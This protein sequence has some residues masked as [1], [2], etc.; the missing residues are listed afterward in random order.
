MSVLIL[1]VEVTTKNK[2]SP[3]TKDNKLCQIGLME[4]SATFNI[5]DIEYSE[6]PYGKYLNEVQDYIQKSHLLVGFNIKFDLHWLRRYGIDFSRSRIWDC[7]IAHFLITNQQTKFPSLDGVCEYYGLGQ[8]VDKIKHY[9]DEGIDTPNISWDELSEYLKQDL[10]L[11]YKVYLKQKEYFDSHPALYR[12][13]F[14][15][16]LDLPILQEMEWNGMRFDKETSLALSESTVEQCNTIR[17]K[18]SWDAPVSFTSGDHISAL[19]YGG[20]IKEKYREK[21]IFQYK[22]GR[23]AEKERWSVKEHTMPQLVKPLPKSEMAKEGFYATDKATLT[24]IARKRISKEIK[25]LI[26]DII[27]YGDLDH[28]NGTYYEGLPKQMD[29]HGD[30]EYI[31][32][33]FNQVVAV[34]GRLSSSKPNLQNRDRRIDHCFISRYD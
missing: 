24:Q 4:P 23:Q 34:T 16:M 5:Y 27:E 28:L 15:E 12:L 18:Y 14:L 25:Q 3:F 30:E 17:N 33:Q 2:G 26:E 19:L 7:Q 21:Y 32:G 31:H 8:K 29:L 11:T 1:D 20:T 6:H 13:F 22:D 9:W 10:S